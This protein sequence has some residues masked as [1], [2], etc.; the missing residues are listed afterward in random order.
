M[1]PRILLDFVSE[2][3]ARGLIYAANF[4][5]STTISGV[6]PA[7][8]SSS[9]TLPSSTLTETI[10]ARGRLAAGMTIAEE[11]QVVRYLPGQEFK[12][13][14]DAF[15]ESEDGKRALTMY[16][17]GQRDVTILIY[18]DSPEEGGETVFPELGLQVAPI[19][20]AALIWRN[21][22]SDGSVDPLMLHGGAPVQR[23]VKYAVNLWFRRGLHEPVMFNGVIVPGFM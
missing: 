12:P 13:H 8:T 18:L 4:D 9:A 10:R 16:G 20:R 14:L 15:D 19:P 1:L 17:G 22:R 3:E 11:L 23:G 21:V 5:R 7:R 2:P 6:H